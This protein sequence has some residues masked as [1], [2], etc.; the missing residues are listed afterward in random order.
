M[1][2]TAARRDNDS[3]SREEMSTTESR[4]GLGLGKS[5]GGGWEADIG[6]LKRRNSSDSTV[7]A[8]PGERRA[9]RIDGKPKEGQKSLGKKSAG[10]RGNLRFLSLDLGKP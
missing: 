3:D 4:V 1:V 8:E 7:E 2:A 5:R 9:D 6:A 10:G